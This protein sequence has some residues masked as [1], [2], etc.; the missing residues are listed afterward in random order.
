M[1]EPEPPWRLCTLMLALGW[2]LTFSCLT[3]NASAGNLAVKTL[4]P[5]LTHL[6]ST[7]L[8][9]STF[10]NGL[11]NLALPHIFGRLGRWKAY[12][13]GTL[14]GLMGS[15]LCFVALAWARSLPLLLLGAILLGC[16]LC[17]GANY[18][19]G[20]LLLGVPKAHAPV[21]ISWVLAGGVVGAVL[22]PEYA[23]HLKMAFAEFPFAGVYI[24]TAC[25]MGLHLLLLLAGARVL[26]FGGQNGTRTAEDLPPPPAR[27][28]RVVFSQPACWGAT[29]VA[30]I[31]YSVMVFL[32]SA[33]PLSMGGGDAVTTDASAFTF[34][35]T[36]TVVQLHM[37]G[38]FAPSFVT[39]NVINALGCPKVMHI[40]ASLFAV[41]CTIM[42][43][44]R[45]YAAYM[46]GQ[47]ILG[48]GWNFCFI[49]ASAALAK[50]ARPGTEAV[51]VQSANDVAVFCSSGILSMLSASALGGVGWRGMQV[52]GIAT[53]ALLMLMAYMTSRPVAPATTIANTAVP[54]VAV[55]DETSAR[56]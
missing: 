25:A 1:P 21:A 15:F 53:A 10:A 3:A 5:D 7:V 46:F 20:V 54:A 39:G 32:M 43:S 26:R 52:V 31:S 33:L 27:P 40:G 24:G 48:V 14:L 13:L 17:F 37:V 34:A 36:S 4:V 6:H 49:A 30:S 12:I 19:F 35:Q 9:C 50:H 55:E 41:A 18:R 38:M 56:A 16:G 28:L 23:K 22:G 51:R 42:I 11:M 2:A 45:Q 47:C 29:M 44:S 8:A